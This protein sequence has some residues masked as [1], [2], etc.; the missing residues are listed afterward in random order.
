MLGDQ[1]LP[2]RFGAALG[3]ALVALG[4]ADGI[5]VTGDGDVEFDPKPIE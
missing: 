5:G 4:A 3:E 2:G 1:V